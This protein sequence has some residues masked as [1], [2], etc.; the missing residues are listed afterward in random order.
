MDR[1]LPPRQ[2]QNLRSILRLP[3][4]RL[5]RDSS[6][7]P[8]C[9]QLQTRILRPLNLKLQPRKKKSNK[10]LTMHQ[11]RPKVTLWKVELIRILSIVLVVLTG[12]YRKKPKILIPKKSVNSTLA[13]FL[14]IIQEQPEYTKCKQQQ[15][16]I[17]SLQKTSICKPTTA[18]K[19]RRTHNSTVLSSKKNW[20]RGTSIKQTK[21]KT[22][23]RIFK[24]SLLS[25]IIVPR[26]SMTLRICT[27]I[28]SPNYNN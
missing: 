4:T 19:R 15:T 9:R 17:S 2:I 8:S 24:L 25:N 5:S 18:Y 20:T 6:S 12:Q 16:Q 27:A 26:K 14:T 7:N 1:V 13:N 3:I 11:Q 28:L 23:Q 21:Q 22:S 10:S